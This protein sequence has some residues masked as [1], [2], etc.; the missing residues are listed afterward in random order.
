MNE[1]SKQEVVR[2]PPYVEEEHRQLL[3]SA[4]SALEDY[5]ESLISKIKKEL[6]ENGWEMNPHPS[7]I[8]KAERSF[9]DDPIRHQ[10]ARNLSE[11]RSLVER[12]RFMIKATSPI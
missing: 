8:A 3:A 11:I 7:D 6:F 9:R 12:P 1:E 10:L 2:L 5:S 4:E